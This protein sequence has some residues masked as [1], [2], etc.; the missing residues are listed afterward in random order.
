[1]RISDWSSRVLFRSQQMKGIDNL[2]YFSSTSDSAGNLAITLT[3]E[4][5]TDPDIA[6]VQVQNKLAQATPLLPQ[7]V[8][9]QGIRVTKAVK[10]FLLVVAL[11]S[12]DGSHDQV[13]IGDYVA[14]RIQ[15][16]LSRIKGVGDTQVLGA[17]YAMRIWRDP[18]KMTT[19]NLAISDVKAAILAQNAQVSAGQVGSLPSVTGQALK[20]T[21][22]AQSRL[23]TPEQFRNILL[24]TNPDGST[25]HLSDVARVELEI[26]RAHV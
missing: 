13:D 21:I 8:Q 2:R 1:M 9:Q 3:F 14:S 15:D 23:R 11:Y 20:A 10:N 26:G 12:E 22:T 18:F 5:G 25:V 19:Y 7:E 16:P 6:Q 4:Q 17:Q 24:R